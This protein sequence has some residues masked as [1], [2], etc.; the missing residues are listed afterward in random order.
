MEIVI[1]KTK[2][3]KV[4]GEDRIMY[5]FFSKKYLEEAAKTFNVIFEKVE[6]DKSFVNSTGL[7]IFDVPMQHFP[8]FSPTFR[9][10]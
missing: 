10:E 3:N 7:P 5:E 9:P 2:N 6:I 4:P 1:N 8:S